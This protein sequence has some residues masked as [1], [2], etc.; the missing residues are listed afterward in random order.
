MR[1]RYDLMN[2]IKGVGPLSSICILA[3]LMVLP[4]DMTASQWVAHA[5]L[6]P[7][8]HSSGTS[9]NGGS[10]ISKAGNKYLRAALFM[11][12][13]S[14]SFHNPHVQSFSRK[15]VNRGKKPIQAVIAVMRKLLHSI[16]GMFAHDK[17]FDGNRF[18]PILEG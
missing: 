16:W 14:A 9:V 4:Q 8:E 18:H 17:P 11:P 5:G 15:L 2:T 12:A 13:L 6:D 7:R 3:E 10:R 1:R